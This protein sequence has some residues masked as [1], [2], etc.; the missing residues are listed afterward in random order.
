[1][2]HMEMLQILVIK[3]WCSC[4][5]HNDPK[6]VDKQVWANSVDHDQTD[7]SRAIWSVYILFSIPAAFLDALPA[8]NI[9]E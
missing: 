6:F 4:D 2:F 3:V 1:M 5:Y 7:P 8:V 9:L